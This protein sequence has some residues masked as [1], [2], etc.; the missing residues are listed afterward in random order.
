MIWKQGDWLGSQSES[1]NSKLDLE[2]R[3]LV[4]YM[5]QH[6]LFDSLIQKLDPDALKIKEFVQISIEIEAKE[7]R[8][9]ARTL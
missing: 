2:A 7:D 3:G 8:N 6:I 9:Q 4:N 5:D 1:S